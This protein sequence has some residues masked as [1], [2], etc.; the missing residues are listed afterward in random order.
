MAVVLVAFSSVINRHDIARGDVSG[1]RTRLL[2]H[3]V[4]QSYV[5]EGATSHHSVVTSTS[6]VR[7]E[8][9]RF[10]SLGLQ[11]GSSRGGLSNVSSR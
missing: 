10:D 6:T 1:V 7:V 8:V 5:G 3:L 9:F 2:D 4:N 11:P